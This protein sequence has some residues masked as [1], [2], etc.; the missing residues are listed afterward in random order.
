MG[1][2]IPETFTSE[3]TGKDEFL[4]FVLS[5]SQSVIDRDGTIRAVEGYGLLPGDM[6]LQIYR[7][8]CGND[9]CPFPANAI[10]CPDQSV[11]CMRTK[12]CVNPV[13]GTKELREIC[14][15]KVTGPQFPEYKI[16]KRVKLTL[17]KGYFFIRLSKARNLKPGDLIA[18]RTRGGQITKRKVEGSESPDWKLDDGNPDEPLKIINSGQIIPLRDIKYMIRILMYEDIIFSPYHNYINSSQFQVSMKVSTPWGTEVT[19]SRG[20]TVAAAV[21]KLRVRVVPPNSAV[22][23]PVSVS[24]IM[25]SGSQVQISWD[26]GDGKKEDETVDVSVPNDPFTRIH[27]YTKPGTFLIK[28]KAKNIKSD[29]TSDHVLIAQHPVSKDWKLSTDSPQL[30]PGI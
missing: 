10:L 22:G 6:E 16:Y 21:N 7:P 19:Q 3:E 29:V 12:T 25:N 11:L 28:V 15:Q 18:L 27:N 30:L 17:L 20:I 2:F 1:P 26:F 24:I 5:E 13:P 9:S 8:H 14:R 23:Q 4:T